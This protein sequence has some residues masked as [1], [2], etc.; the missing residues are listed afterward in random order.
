ML[1]KALPI[2]RRGTFRSARPREARLDIRQTRI[3][4]N[5]LS[6]EK[7]KRK[8][9]PNH[10]A[11]SLWHD[12]G[13]KEFSQRKLLRSLLGSFGLFDGLGIRCDLG[14]LD[15]GR[16]RSLGLLGDGSV[17]LPRRSPSPW[18]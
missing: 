5:L 4:A 3:R 6:A 11:E 13:L 2:G 15:L 12:S 8:K 7:A 14:R 18:S 1:R 9:A 16:L 10:A 17:V